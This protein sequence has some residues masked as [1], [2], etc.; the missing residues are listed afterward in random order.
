[1]T[2]AANWNGGTVFLKHTTIDDS[3]DCSGQDFRAFQ[4][5]LGTKPL[6]V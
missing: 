4:C 1:M 6:N 2:L 5:T 3:L